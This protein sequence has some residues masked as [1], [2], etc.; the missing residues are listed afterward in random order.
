MTAVS[1]TPAPRRAAEAPGCSGIGVPGRPVRTLIGSRPALPVIQ[2]VL[3]PGALTIGGPAAAGPEIA[4]TRIGCLARP[5]ARFTG[6]TVNREVAMNATPVRWRA[7]DAAGS[8]AARKA[9]A[10]MAGAS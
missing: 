5:L 9:N 2:M 6:T 1:G 10:G 3:P 8:G 4:G 7:A